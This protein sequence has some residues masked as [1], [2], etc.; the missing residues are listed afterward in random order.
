MTNMILSIYYLIS[1]K[2]Y[3]KFKNTWEQILVIIDLNEI[4]SSFYPKN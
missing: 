2:A 4:I 1:L 3:K